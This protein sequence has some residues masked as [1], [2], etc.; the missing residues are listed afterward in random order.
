[1]STQT[2]T[3]GLIKVSAALAAGALALAA[4]SSGGGGA[5][6]DDAGGSQDVTFWGNWTGEQAAQIEAQVEAFNSSQEDYVVTYQ[7]QEEVEAKLLTAIAGGGVP[8][9]VLWDRFQTS[10][11]ASKGALMSL[12]DLISQDSLDTSIFYEAALNELTYDGTVYGL[13]LTVDNRSLFYNVDML[14][15][16]G[17]EPPTTWAELADAAEALTVR[18]DGGALVR[19]GFALN[20]VGLFSMWLGQAGGQMVSDDGTTA[21]FNTP[22]GLAVLE[23]WDELMNE[24]GVYELGFAEGTDGFAEGTV[25]M[26]YNGPWMLASYDALEGLNYGIMPAPAGPD[27]D[28]ASGLGGFGLIIPE[29]APNAEGAWE[30]MTWWTAQ[31]ENGV[32]FAEASGNMPANLEAAEDP[33]FTENEAYSALLETMS[34]ATARPTVPG[35]SDAE[36]QGLIPELQRFMA[37]EITAQEALDNAEESF[38]RI[39]AENA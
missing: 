29:G 10:V 22:E 6:G 38:N 25:A 28:Q 1:M 34:F 21:A 11:Y 35:Y 30:F 13:P 23:Q 4:C 3:A 31:A 37:G 15:E 19:S 9:V 14:A 17:V 18:D 36:V 12:E 16:A 20:D 39:L 33:F 2:R 26:S 24:R 27:G 5:G 32:A 8:D 7:P